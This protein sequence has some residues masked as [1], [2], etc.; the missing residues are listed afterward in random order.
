MGWRDQVLYYR[1]YYLLWVEKQLEQG[2]AYSQGMPTVESLSH[3]FFLVGTIKW[4][5]SFLRVW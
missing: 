2:W 5:Q 1:I 4:Y 3:M